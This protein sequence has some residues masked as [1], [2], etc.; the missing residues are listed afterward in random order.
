MD[1]NGPYG[2]PRQSVLQR[3]QASAD[4][5]VKTSFHSAKAN[6]SIGV[7]LIDQIK[8][9]T[10]NLK[11]YVAYVILDF[12][13]A[14]R[15]LEHAPIALALDVCEQLGIKTLFSDIARKE[16]RLRK[17]QMDLIG[18]T[19]DEL[20]AAAAQARNQVVQND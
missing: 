14:D 8:N 9:A 15:D 4:G 18:E 20:I 1:A 2:R 6:K 5:E 3:L 7:E 12:V 11:K 13:A 10:E 17:K 19:R 16:L